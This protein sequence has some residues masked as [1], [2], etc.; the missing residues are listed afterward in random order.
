MTTEISFFG[1]WICPIDAAT[2]DPVIGR[3]DEEDQENGLYL[4]AHFSLSGAFLG[5]ILLDMDMLKDCKIFK[6]EEDAQDYI[7]VTWP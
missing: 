5:Y 1:N 4:L 2:V 6:G 3:I 7:A